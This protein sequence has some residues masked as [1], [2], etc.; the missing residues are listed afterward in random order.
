MADKNKI[1]KDWG[2]FKA[3]I[4]GLLNGLSGSIYD[5][6]DVID[7]IGST[8]EQLKDRKL[9]PEFMILLSLEGDCVIMT[10]MI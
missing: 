4:T 10:D 6:N 2:D 5:L 3:A 7:N 1:K 9:I 8:S